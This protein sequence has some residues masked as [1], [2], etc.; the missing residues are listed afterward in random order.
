MTIRIIVASTLLLLLAACKETPPQINYGPKPHDTDFTA[1][2]ESPQ[3]RIVVIEEFTGVACP[4]CPQGHKVLAAI[5]QQYPNRVAFV[6]IQAY[7][8]PQANPLDTPGNEIYTRHDNRTQDGTDLANGIFGGLSNIPIAGIDRTSPAGNLLIGRTAWNSV[9]DNRIN[10]STAANVSLTLNYDDNS[11]KAIIVVHVAYTQAI[12][13]MQRLTLALTE[14][15]VIDGQ[16][17]DGPNGYNQ[18]YVHMHVLR[19]IL[20]AP[21]G[22]LILSNYPSKQAGLVYERTFVYTLSADWNPEHCKV[23]AYVANDNGNDKEII[24]GAEAHLK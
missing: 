6:G 10:V 19:D 17:G 23:V 14:D 16:E 21:T 4:P 15:S 7:G 1:T 12:A 13:K 5:E 24:Q 9:V 22:D 11:R 20:T 2:P 18:N 3:S 8:V